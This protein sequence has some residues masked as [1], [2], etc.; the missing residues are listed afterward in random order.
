V[1]AVALLAVIVY[2]A[3]PTRFVLSRS[4]KMRLLTLAALFCA[5]VL[6]VGQD[7]GA[8]AQSCWTPAKTLEGHKGQVCQIAFSPDGAKLASASVDG[9]IKIWS[10]SSGLVCTTVAV[11][12]RAVAFS[13]DGKQLATGGTDIRFWDSTTGK[14]NGIAYHFATEPPSCHWHMQ[15]IG[16]LL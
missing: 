11:P 8:Q 4:D 16:N 7:S 2:P 6:G 9:T 12:A 14:E 3:F 10:L 13:P 15:P 5:A 1:A